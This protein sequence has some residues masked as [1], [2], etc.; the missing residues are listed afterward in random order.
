MLMATGLRQTD[1]FGV[2]VEARPEVVGCM[3]IPNPCHHRLIGRKSSNDS[4]V[5]TTTISGCPQRC[6]CHCYH[7]CRRRC[8]RCH[9]RR[10]C[11]HCCCC[12]HC[13]W[14]IGRVPHIVAIIMEEW[15]GCCP[16]EHLSVALRSFWYNK[17]SWGN[18][19]PHAGNYPPKVE[20]Q[21]I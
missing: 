7:C 21:S 9:C 4:I 11:H 15:G 16:L 3:S 19:M 17:K 6:C 12:R 1:E 8:C 5:V 2:N 20:N 10:H 18:Y 14:L 13:G